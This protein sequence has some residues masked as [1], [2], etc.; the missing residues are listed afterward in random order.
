ME[1]AAGVLRLMC[2]L[3]VNRYS[4]DMYEKKCGRPCGKSNQ[5][6]DKK[7]SCLNNNGT[8]GTAHS[9]RA[10]TGSRL[11]SRFPN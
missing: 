5:H 11:Q 10:A 4:H 7:K 9:G 2:T 3:N 6:R 8:S 1:T